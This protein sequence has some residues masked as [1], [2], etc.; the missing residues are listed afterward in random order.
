MYESLKD[1]A[2]LLLPGV[3]RFGNA[4]T[5]KNIKALN[6]GFTLRPCAGY[7]VTEWEPENLF[8]AMRFSI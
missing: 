5:E 6:F 3:R 4:I 1:R 8:C 2:Y 7:L